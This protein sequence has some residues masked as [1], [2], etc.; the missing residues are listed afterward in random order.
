[1]TRPKR[2]ED[3]E[4]NFQCT[5]CDQ[6]KFITDFY[7]TPGEPYI[8]IDNL[9]YNKPYSICKDCR[10]EYSKSERAKERRRYYEWKRYYTDQGKPIPYPYPY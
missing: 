4:G 9:W 7:L 10:K 5:K 2:F 8:F 3:S 6:L 1:M